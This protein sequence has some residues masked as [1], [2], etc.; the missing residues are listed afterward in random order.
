MSYDMN[1]Y[2]L[3]SYIND[4]DEMEEN[5]LYLNFSKEKWIDSKGIEHFISDLNDRYLYNILNFLR[6][7]DYENKDEHI[8][9]IENE[10]DERLKIKYGFCE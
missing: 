10:L 3:D 1:K 7:S 2:I 9:Y 5:K 4:I 8:L 6:K